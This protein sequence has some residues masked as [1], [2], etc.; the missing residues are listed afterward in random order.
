MPVLAFLVY[1]SRKGRTRFIDQIY[2]TKA[3]RRTG[4]GVK[5]LGR[6]ST[7]PIELV[8]RRDNAEAIAAYLAL[9]FCLAESPGGAYKIDKSTEFYMRTVSFRKTKRL[10]QDSLK[11]K[12]PPTVTAD[13]YSA[14]PAIPSKVREFM[15]D[16]V[17]KSE[18][19]SKAEA[20]KTVNP[21]A[22]P[23][24]HYVVLSG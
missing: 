2:V 15:V 16:A 21:G 22:S 9:G 10:M 12:S 5:L 23:R 1:H 7:G 8:V 11:R 13:E 4:L 24:V 19:V 6:L 3:Q 20:L 18:G 17:I 14:W